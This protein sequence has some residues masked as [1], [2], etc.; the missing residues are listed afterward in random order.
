MQLTPDI[1]VLSAVLLPLVGAVLAPLLQRVLRA[2]A[3]WVLALIPAW[4]FVALYGLAPELA[5]GAR[6]TVGWDWAPSWNLRLSF[7]LDGLSLTFALAI[8]GIGALVVLY[9]ASYLKGHAHQGRFMGFLMGFMAAMQ[10]LVLADNLVA[11]YLFWELTSV[12]SFLLIGFDHTRQAARR[13]ATQALIVTAIGGLALLAAGV[14]IA[15]TSGT[16][17]LSGAAPLRDLPVYPVLVLLVLLAAFTKSAQV[18]FH[19]WLPNAMEAPTPVSAYLHSATMVQAGVYLVA[20]LTPHLGGE[21]IWNG[22]LLVFGGVTMLWGGIQAF[23]QTDL[24]QMLAQ[25]TLAS[26]GLLMLLLGAGTELAVTAAVLYFVAHALYKAALFL[27]AGAVDHGT[28][29]RDITALGGLRDPMTVTFIATIMAAGAMIGVPPLVAFFAKEE[30]YLAFT[31]ADPAALLTLAALIAGNALLGGVALLVL[32]RPF[33]GQLLPTPIAP[34]EAKLPMLVGPLLL[35]AAGIVLGFLPGPLAELLVVPT[36]AAILGGEVNTHMHFGF[37]PLSLVF[38]LSVATWGL[39]IVAYRFADH[40]RTALREAAGRLGWSFDRGFDQAYF[41]LV[42]LAA[43]A[44]RALHHGRLEWYLIVVFVALGCAAFGPLWLLDGL[45][46]LAVRW[47]ATFYEVGVMLVAVIGLALV[48]AART[49]LLAILALGVQGA[50]VALLFVFYG[51]PDLG[52]T[53]FMVEIVSVV[54]LALVMTRLRLDARD[55][56]PLEDWARDGAL[57]AF[58]GLAVTTLLFRVLEQ[59]LSRLL[60]EFFERASLPLAHGRNVVNVILV[61]FRALDTLGEI[62]VVFTAG[63]AVLALLRGPG[64]PARHA[65]PELARERAGEVAT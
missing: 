18:P 12:A 15:L 45:P 57:A 30:M 36:V 7:L 49:R 31:L 48:V 54:I 59:P 23:R 44:T 6:L 32:I 3:G 40:G 25:T 22:T 17:D 9:S 2:Y 51:A 8:A 42:R 39:A 5:D 13:A 53:Q 34:H 27:V 52:F 55:P 24:K 58:A 29:T 26:L 21:P 61:D 20:R 10:G 56:R 37:D 4:G 16:W 46:S 1:A 50:A 65:D 62:A 41:G 43:G 28:G 19:F 38:W 47:D 11:L 60:P 35:A 63:I 14:A 64:K 33:M